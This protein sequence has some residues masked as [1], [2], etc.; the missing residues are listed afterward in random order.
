MSPS[1]SICSLRTS[2]ET[3]ASSV[4]ASLLHAHP[5]LEHGPLLDDRLLLVE[6]DLVLLLG[7]LRPVERR[8]D[9]PVADR[10]AL[11]ADLLTPHRDRLLDLLGDHV[12]AQPGA[13]ALAVRLAGPE[14]LLR[15]SHRL[16]GRG[17]PKT[18][19]PGAA[20]ADPPSHTSQERFS[21][22]SITAAAMSSRS[23][24]S[25]ERHCR[26]SC[27]ITHRLPSVLSLESTSGRPMYAITSRSSI[28]RLRWTSGCLR[29]SLTRSG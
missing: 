21:T 6:H 22:R 25:C 17:S 13:S 14:L 10:L 19:V 27:S 9:V 8:V 7:D 2:S 28:A 20:T 12:L 26:G 18:R 3:C 11:D 4:T 29:A 15:A 23:S 1:A 16:V 5:L 24:T